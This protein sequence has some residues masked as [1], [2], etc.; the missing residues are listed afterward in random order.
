LK[1]ANAALTALGDPTRQEIVRLLAKTPLAVHEIAARLPVSRPAVSKH[2]RVLTDAG[3][4]DRRSYG[5][6]NVYA[7]EPGGLEA[8]RAYLDGL[9][10]EAL[11]RYRLFAQN[12]PNERNKTERKERR[13]R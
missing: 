11:A 13:Q 1:K 7:L 3:L 8:L 2:L 9:W 6:R 10:E 4:V 12:T 5:T